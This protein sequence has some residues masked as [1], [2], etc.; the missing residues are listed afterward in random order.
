MS[1]RCSLCS[2][3]YPAG[4]GE[5]LRCGGPLRSCSD[6]VSEHWRDAPVPGLSD[7]HAKVEAWR[8]YVL[9]EAGYPSELAEQLTGA[10]VDLH[11]AVDLVREHGCQPELAAAILL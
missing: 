11:Q 8:L 6:P 1:Q 3:N 4:Y 5:C 9:L 2:V 10:D 7:N